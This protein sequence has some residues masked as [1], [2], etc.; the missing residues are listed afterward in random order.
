MSSSRSFV[1]LFLVFVVVMLC[2][3]ECS[4]YPVV[5][6]LYEDSQVYDVDHADPSVPIVW[7]FYGSYDPNAWRDDGVDPGSPAAGGYRYYFEDRSALYVIQRG[8]SIVGF[9]LYPQA[10]FWFHS[11]LEKDV[12]K[13]LKGMRDNPEVSGWVT[14]RACYKSPN[15]C[16]DYFELFRPGL[17][18]SFDID[19][20]KFVYLNPRYSKDTFRL[21]VKQNAGFNLVGDGDRVNGAVSQVASF[22]RYFMDLSLH[23]DVHLYRRGGAIVGVEVI[24][25]CPVESDGM[26]FFDDDT[27]EYM[28]SRL[29]DLEARSLAEGDTMKGLRFVFNERGHA[30][31][32]KPSRIGREEDSL[33]FR[34]GIVERDFPSSI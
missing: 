20:V 2:V 33:P 19:A 28:Q 27:T 13:R 6:E 9:V 11:S 5:G 3:W 16:D 15:E 29:N 4:A 14:F 25:D 21:P 26:G 23:S 31:I 24:P 30:L 7:I 10:N 34:F 1:S 32:Y 12:K 17:G 18:G 22:K 8:D